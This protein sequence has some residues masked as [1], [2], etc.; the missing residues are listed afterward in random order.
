MELTVDRDFHVR[1]IRPE[2]NGER[3]PIQTNDD[4]EEIRRHLDDTGVHVSGFLLANAF[5]RPDLDREIAWVARVAQVAVSL[6]VPVVRIDAIMHGE[7]DLPLDERQRHF[8]DAMT[9]VLRTLGDREVALGIENHGFQGNDPAFL[10]GLIAAVNDGR[11]GLTLDTGNFYWSG[12][13]LREVYQ[14]IEHFAPL[15]MHTH[16]KNIAYPAED[17]ERQR[18]LGWKYGEYVCPLEDGDIDLLLVHDLLRDA[19]YEHDLCIEDESL[20]RFP[21]EQRREVLRQDADYLRRI[22]GS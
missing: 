14:A 2:R 19:G 10:D 8:A 1:A 5:G 20:G 11:L 18:D 6:A 3:L 21:E 7:R 12:K 15:T 16:V 22:I 17:R 9:R 13:P 4:V